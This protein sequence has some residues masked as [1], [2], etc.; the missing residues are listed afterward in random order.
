RSQAEANTTDLH[1]RAAR[2][3]SASADAD[4]SVIPAIGFTI[5]SIR[6]VARKQ[7]DPVFARTTPVDVALP[8]GDVRYPD[9]VVG[10][11]HSIDPAEACTPNIQREV[12]MPEPETAQLRL[13]VLLLAELFHD[14]TVTFAADSHCGPDEHQ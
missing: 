4:S 12:F 5:H 7:L 8:R 6:S 9:R 13:E 10:C 11:P 2:V 14:P 1:N 3:S